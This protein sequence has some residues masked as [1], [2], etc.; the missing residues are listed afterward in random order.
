MPL[1]QRS[2]M[3]ECHNSHV[4]VESIQIKM[5]RWGKSGQISFNACFSEDGRYKGK[6]STCSTFLPAAFGALRHTFRACIID[7]YNRT[8]LSPTRLWASTIPEVA[9]GT[10]VRINLT[11]VT[12]LHWEHLSFY[13][14]Y[15][16]L[17]SSPSTLG[18]IS[19]FFHS[20]SIASTYMARQMLFQWPSH[21]TNQCNKGIIDVYIEYLSYEDHLCGFWNEWSR[22]RQYKIC[23][24]NATLQHSELILICITHFTVHMK[25]TGKHSL[26]VHHT[27]PQAV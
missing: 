15:F 23:N 14:V 1:Y 26:T 4:V 2:A 27:D 9:T 18:R 24:K 7:V 13:T 3:T 20:V 12:G 10:A 5:R 16:A 22:K 17:S 25:C 6:T 11:G 8:A 19:E 21:S